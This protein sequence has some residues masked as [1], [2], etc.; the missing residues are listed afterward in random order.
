M[1]VMVIIPTVLRAF[2]DKQAEISVEGNTVGE[3]ISSF[4]D[5]H[6]DIKQH[7]YDKNGTLRS[8]INLYLGDTNIKDLQGI[9]TVVK[10]GDTVT[11]V[12]AIAGGRQ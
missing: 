3:V 1:A 10:N 8:F 7:L 11:L 4:T 5:K 12:P 2:T 9:D 6:P